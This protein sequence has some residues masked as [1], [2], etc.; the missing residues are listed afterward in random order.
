MEPALE[1]AGVRR[2]DLEDP[3]G[4]LPCLAIETILGAAMQ[5]RPMKNLGMRLAAETP[6]GAFPLIDYL[7]VTSEN[8]GAGLKQLAR[9]L[10]LGEAPYL[11]N[12]RE[13]EDPIRILYEGSTDPFSIELG[14]DCGLASSEGN[15]RPH[16]AGVC[17]LRPSSG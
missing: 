12:L 4:R 10:R 8:V 5:E 7:V 2:L 17:Q 13:D 14:D 16:Q 6:L 11:R 3:D 1:K 9:Y 15:R